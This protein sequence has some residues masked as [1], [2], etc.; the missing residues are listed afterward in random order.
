[1]TTAFFQLATALAKKS[2]PDVK[3]SLNALQ[4]FH[5]T[6]RLRNI[7]AVVLCLGVGAAFGI[8]MAFN[9]IV[10]WL[11]KFEDAISGFGLIRLWLLLGIGMIAA[12]NFITIAV[13]SIRKR[14]AKGT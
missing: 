4:D 3:S 5:S 6:Y 8:V 7:I 13:R 1:M 2:E 14:K 10:I 9:D 12:A 11:G